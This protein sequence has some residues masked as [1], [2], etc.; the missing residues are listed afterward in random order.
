ML[1]DIKSSIIVKVTNRKIEVLSED[2]RTLLGE[3]QL[4]DNDQILEACCTKENLLISTSAGKVLYFNLN[5][6]EYS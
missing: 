3:L 4:P 6:Q 2:F 1:V 5:T